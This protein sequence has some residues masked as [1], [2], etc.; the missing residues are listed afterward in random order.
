MPRQPP[1]VVLAGQ[2][3][4]YAPIIFRALLARAEH[5]EIALVVEGVRPSALRKLHRMLEPTGESLAADR[6]SLRDNA[7]AAGVPVL[8]T[9]DINDAEAVEEIER[10]GGD[11]L[12]CA[13]FDRLFRAPVLESVAVAGFNAHP[14]LLPELRGPSP[15]FWAVKEGRQEIGVTVHGLDGGEDH[16]PIYAQQSL[17]RPSRATGSVLF[18]RCAAAAG[19]MLAKTLNSAILKVLKGTAQDHGKATRAP[20][21]S[22]DD[23]LV[24][25]GDWRCAHLVDFAC[26]AP[27]FRRPIMVLGNDRFEVLR[28]LGA[29]PGERLPGHYAQ[30]SNRVAV[31]CLDGIA[32]LEVRR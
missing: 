4:P 28:G 13:G 30:V 8:Q 15:L 2:S 10:C 29:Q 12:V 14:S 5:F 6:Q 11:Y 32:H 23:V 25:P 24:A 9:R 7:L 22:A 17:P 26:A 18:E 19:P 20:R 3:G 21:P 31:Q 16:G 27:F 1:R